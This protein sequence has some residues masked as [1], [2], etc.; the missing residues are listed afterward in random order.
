MYG[1]I[2]LKTEDLDRQHCDMVMLVVIGRRYFPLG[3][4]AVCIGKQEFG[5]RDSET[6]LVKAFEPAFEKHGK[7]KWERSAEPGGHYLIG[8]QMKRDYAYEA[9]IKGR[10]NAKI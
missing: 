5:A 9:A 10:L 3:A 8:L 6:G 4:K 1:K 2:P 7:R